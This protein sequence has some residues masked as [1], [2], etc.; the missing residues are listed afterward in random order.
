VRGVDGPDDYASMREVL[1]RRFAGAQTKGA[2]NRAGKGGADKNPLPDLL[3]I[4]GGKGQLNIA[5]AVLE[6]LGISGLDVAAL[7]KDKP[8]QGKVPPGARARALKPSKGERVFLPNVKDPVLL[9]EGSK[10]D[11][12]LRRIRDE[13]HRSAITYHRR[14]R[15]KGVASRLEG[16][17][18]IGRKK[19]QLLL[20]RFGDLEGVRRASA[21]ELAEVPGI[22]GA[23]AKV[24]IEKLAEDGNGSG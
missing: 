20:E 8:I 10:P 13:V 6:E 22:T 4:D 11:L 1:T 15:S 12:L 18:G 9:R 7:A 3:L 16:I 21:K 2:G 24:I 17:P 14:L 23:L 19:T 5:L